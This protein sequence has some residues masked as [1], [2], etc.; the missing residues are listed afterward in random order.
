MTLT[1]QA[2]TMILARSARRV[3]WADAL[4]ERRGVGATL[5][6]VCERVDARH[7]IG[8]ATEAQLA[9]DT[10][11]TARYIRTCLNRLEDL[12]VITWVRGWRRGT[13]SRPSRFRVSKRALA[14]LVRLIRPTRDLEDEAAR[15]A[16]I[17][18]T[19]GRRFGYKRRSTPPELGSAL[20]PFQGVD[21][22]TGARVARSWELESYCQHDS[23]IGRCPSCRRQAQAEAPPAPLRT[24]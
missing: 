15:A 11:M 13:L 19:A 4:G 18:R 8:V 24:T 14:L 16:A 1:A 17:A 23:I 3:G 9:R 10:G 2:P 5:H 12:G 21:T 22:A 7:G 20:P 6:A